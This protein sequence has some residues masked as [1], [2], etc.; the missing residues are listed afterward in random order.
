M[1][2]KKAPGVPGGRI[3]DEGEL[4]SAELELARLLER[5]TVLEGRLQARGIREARLERRGPDAAD[6]EARRLLDRYGHQHALEGVEPSVELVA[7]CALGANV[8]ASKRARLE[9]HMHRRTHGLA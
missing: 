8:D 1:A 9:V 6:R 5:I 2:T 7:M 3:P 4:P